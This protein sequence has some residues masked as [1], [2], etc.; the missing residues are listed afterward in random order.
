MTCLI[1][2]IKLKKRTRPNEEHETERKKES[3]QNLVWLVDS[4]IGSRA[5]ASHTPFPP[6]V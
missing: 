2:Q 3:R 1:V 6:I 5:H 4:Y